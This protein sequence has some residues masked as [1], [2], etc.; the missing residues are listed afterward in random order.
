[1]LDPIL[2]RIAKNSI[3]SKFGSEYGLDKEQLLR[4]YPYL[5]ES[6]ATFVTIHYDK[7]LRGCIGSI[8]AHKTL[9]DDIVSNAVSAGFHDPRFTPLSSDELSHL[10]LEVSVLS[11]PK[12]LEYENFD[13][14]IKKVRPHI[15]G[16]ILKHG[17]YQGTFLPQVWEQL[18]KPKDFLEHLSMKAGS[19]PSIYTKHPDI[20]TYQVDA[21]AEK[22][23]E[24]QSL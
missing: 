10:T 16:L 7:N 18:P 19:N 1:M 8:I 23:D 11:E 5:G 6:G 17:G 14:L 24:I 21:I 22:F 13:D 4:N 2:L 9:L 12:I 20:Y 15:D 3:L